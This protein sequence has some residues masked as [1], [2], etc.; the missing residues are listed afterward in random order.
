M[1]PALRITSEHVLGLALCC[2]SV[3]LGL[4]P[5]TQ[6]LRVACPRARNTQLGTSRPIQKIH[7]TDKARGD[8]S[9][10]KPPATGPC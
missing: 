5:L 6:A 3:A 10:Y 1:E 4:L 7:H 8:R 2:T 9:M